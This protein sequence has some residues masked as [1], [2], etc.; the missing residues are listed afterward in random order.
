MP[1]GL[2]CL[3]GPFSVG[4]VFGSRASQIMGWHGDVGQ[5][6]HGASTCLPLPATHVELAVDKTSVSPIN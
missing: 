6:V 3:V 1:N 5:G 2:S 4:R